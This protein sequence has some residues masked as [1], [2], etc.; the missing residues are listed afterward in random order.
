MQVM[1]CNIAPFASAVHLTDSYGSVK[2]ES[3]HKFRSQNPLDLCQIFSLAPV[4]CDVECV[5]P[6]CCSIYSLMLF[7]SRNKFFVPALLWEAKFTRPP[8]K[9]QRGAE[10]KP[11]SE[12]KIDC[13]LRLEE[14]DTKIGT[15]FTIHVVVF[16]SLKVHLGNYSDS[17]SKTASF[18][19]SLLI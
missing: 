17:K 2:I 19:T 16:V 18:L 10:D 6:R 8:K 14:L 5:S 3:R 7:V 1:L 4:D 13:S 15:R 12:R 11:G 9:V